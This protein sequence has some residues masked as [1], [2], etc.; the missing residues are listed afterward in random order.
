MI[1][2]PGVRAVKVT[3]NL[4]NRVAELSK[5]TPVFRTEWTTIEGIMDQVTVETDK[6]RFRIS[7]P[8]TGEEITCT[9]D[10][11]V[12]NLEDVKE[13]LPHRVAVYGRA[14]LDRMGKTTSIEVSKLT[15]LRDESE[16]PRIASMPSIDITSGMDP[17]DYVERVRGGE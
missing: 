3:P 7:H 17:A 5:P 15:Q 14:R 10:Q 6:S 9:F 4:V 11:G 1:S 13:A 16:F 2:S 12:V 8:L